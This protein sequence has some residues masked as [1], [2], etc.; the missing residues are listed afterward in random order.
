MKVVVDSPAYQN[1]V[2]LKEML[3]PLST[4][5]GQVLDL[6]IADETEAQGW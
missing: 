5:D 4:G 3:G 6:T 2:F 1:E